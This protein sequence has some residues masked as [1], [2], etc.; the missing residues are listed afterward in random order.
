MHALFINCLN[1][2]KF[3]SKN[4]KKIITDKPLVIF[5]IASQTQSYGNTISLEATI[6]SHPLPTNIH[7]EKDEK[8]ICSDGRK[9]VIDNSVKES[10]KLTIRCLDFEDGGKYTIIVTNALGST[11]KDIVINVRGIYANCNYQ[12]HVKYL[13]T[14]M[15]L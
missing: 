1:K 10:P 5:E 11:E 2:M 4:V 14:I 8:E 12:Q 7:W 9:F 6:T 15:I 13:C 3:Y